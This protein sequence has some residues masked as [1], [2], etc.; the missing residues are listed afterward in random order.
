MKLKEFKSTEGSREKPMATLESAEAE[1]SKALHYTYRDFAHIPPDTDND[2]ADEEGLQ[3]A[4]ADAIRQATAQTKQGQVPQHYY[5]PVPHPEDA[6]VRASGWIR[7]QRFPVKLYALL[8]Q[9]ALQ[10]IIT[11]MPHGRSWKVLKP[12][13]FETSI[14]PVFFESDNYHSFNRVINAWSFRR[15]STGPDRGSYF[16][17]VRK[18]ICC[19]C[20]CAKAVNSMCHNISH[21]LLFGAGCLSTFYLRRWDCA[22]STSCFCVANH[23]YRN[24]CDDCH[25]L[26]KNCR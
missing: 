5:P 9:P 10:D 14:L 17:E 25:E 3:G 8:A 18:P 2:D 21:G 7:L 13:V 15:K 26:T 11:W 4:L 6:T 24:T 16:H 22:L 12:R 1:D 23:I 19:C 20:C